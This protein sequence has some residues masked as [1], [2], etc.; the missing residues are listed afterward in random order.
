MAGR[1]KPP[2][3]RHKKKVE[4]N[5]ALMVYDLE[6]FLLFLTTQYSFF[7]EHLDRHLYHDFKKQTIPIRLNMQRFHL[8]FYPMI[9]PHISRILKNWVQLHKGSVKRRFSCTVFHLHRAFNYKGVQLNGVVLDGGS[10]AN[11][12]S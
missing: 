3:K 11:G 7:N 9:L 10:V 1:S 12:F 4:I 5:L 6:I 2:S 8:V